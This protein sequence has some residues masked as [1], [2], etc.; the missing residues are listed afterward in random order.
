MDSPENKGGFGHQPVGAWIDNTGELGSL[1]LRPGN[2]APNNPADLILAVDEATGQIPAAWRHR[3]LA[4]SDT[5]GAS[6]EF[7]GWLDQLNTADNGMAVEYFDRLGHH[8]RGPGRGRG[9]AP[10]VLDTGAGCGHRRGT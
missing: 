7:I 5:A 1:L 3:L 6:H 9:A 4:T 10:R 8:H 2:A